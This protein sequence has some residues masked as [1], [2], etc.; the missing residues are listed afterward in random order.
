M[1]SHEVTF[2][3]QEEHNTLDDQ[4]S[5]TIRT[6]SDQSTRRLLSTPLG[7]RGGLSEDCEVIKNANIKGIIFPWYKSYQLWW[8]LTVIGALLTAFVTPYQIA[9]EDDN[10]GI[11]K[12]TADS[13][14]DALEVVF[15]IDIIITFNLAFYKD[16]QIVINRRQIARE[17]CHYMF[18]IDLIGVLPFEK[19][20]C[21][22]AKTFQRSNET[23]LLMVS[24]ARSL[25]FVRLY[26][27]KK[28]SEDLR[29]DA[30]LNLLTFTLLRDFIVIMISCHMQACTM[31]FLA[32][33][34]NFD[35]DTWLYPLNDIDTDVER[36][37]TALYMTI[38]TFCT[39]GYG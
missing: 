7:V 22:I 21:S 4:N 15:C 17:Y 24:I 28:C 6:Y 30:R 12:L 1:P 19:A 14:H 10:S 5:T 35:K 38:T 34:E 31:Y 13:I 26:R 37:V 27:L 9:F 36:Y 20:A 23:T 33:Y 3:L 2:L 32:R 11:L 16:E 18:W 29:F 39:V 8:Y 25:R